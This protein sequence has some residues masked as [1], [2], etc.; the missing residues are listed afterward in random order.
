MFEQ[1]G[2]K[3]AFGSINS[4]IS[5]F[6]EGIVL[7]DQEN[8][9]CIVT[10]SIFH[11]IFRTYKIQLPCNETRDANMLDV[12]VDAD[13]RSP[14]NRALGRWSQHAAILSRRRTEACDGKG[15]GLRFHRNISTTDELIS[16]LSVEGRPSHSLH[17]YNSA[18]L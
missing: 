17:E 16:T 11:Q 14:I 1:E 10:P 7:G 12:D 15:A 2:T 6:Q 8:P 13:A 5:I 18:K 4:G 3:G 9:L